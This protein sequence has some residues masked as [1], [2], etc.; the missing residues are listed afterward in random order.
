[1]LNGTCWLSNR[2]QG[3]AK[4]NA[5]FEQNMTTVLKSH[6]ILMSLLT[7]RVDNKIKKPGPVFLQMAR[8]AYNQGADYM[9]R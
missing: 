9:Y 4:T 3:L 2:S 8:A 1:M 6:G 7:V 5:Y